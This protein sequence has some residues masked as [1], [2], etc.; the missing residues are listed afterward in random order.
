MRLRAAEEI[1]DAAFFKRYGMNPDG[2]PS[3]KLGPG[4]DVP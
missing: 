1:E 3:G 4:S 2:T